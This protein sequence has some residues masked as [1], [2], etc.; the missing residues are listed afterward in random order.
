M[1]HTTILRWVQHYTPEFQ[2][3][4]DR[5]P[6]PVGGSWRMDETYIRVKGQWMYLCR[7]VGK[8]GKPVDFYLSRKRDVNAAKAF[9]RQALLNEALKGQRVPAKI[10]L[11]ASGA[12]HRAVA[13]L[14]GQWRVAE[15]GDSA[16]R[17]VLE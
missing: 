6:R 16:R 1:A 2:K 9:L 5:F 7:A 11:D 12:S 14:Q 10:T 13:E 8:A 4:W 15:T 3:R 17:Q